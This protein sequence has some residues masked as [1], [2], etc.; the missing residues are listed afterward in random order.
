MR[1]RSANHETRRHACHKNREELVW[2]WQNLEE[3]S[4]NPLRTQYLVPVGRGANLGS[5]VMRNLFLRQ[6]QFLQNT[7]MQL[8]HNLNDMDEILS[9]NLSEHADIDPEYL[10]LRNILRSF[11]VRGNPVIQSIE[12]TPETGSYKLLYHAA[13]GKYVKDLMEGTA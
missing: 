11:K 12:R 13:M 9:L 8:V 7:K 2:K 1:N 6:N 10:T 3:E 5:E 4:V